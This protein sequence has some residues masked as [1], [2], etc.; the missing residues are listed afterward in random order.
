MI[1]TIDAERIADIL[2]TAPTWARHALTSADTRV[3]AQG[4]DEI[5]ALIRR[6]LADPAA[7]PDPNQL[8]LPIV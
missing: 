2:T 7:R 6:R 3:R 5:S 1:D 8:A 4:A